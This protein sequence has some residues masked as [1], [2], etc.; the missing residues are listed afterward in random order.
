M[1][2]HG[3]FDIIK[4]SKIEKIKIYLS[5]QEPIYSSYLNL[6]VLG[7]QVT[8]TVMKKTESIVPIV[9]Y[10]NNFFST[11]NFS[12]YV[13]VPTLYLV[14]PTVGG[15]QFQ[16]RS[17]RFLLVVYIGFNQFFFDFQYL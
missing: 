9:E 13:V 12:V 1:S 4:I 6:S 17:I 3:F 2:V 10:C 5:I 8:G 15:V 11:L 16:V 7:Y 14:I